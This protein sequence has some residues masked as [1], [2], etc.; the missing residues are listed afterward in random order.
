MTCN[1]LEITTS[2]PPAYRGRE[3][4][5][6][7]HQLLES[8]LE[9]LMLIVGAAARKQGRIEIC[10]VDCFSGPWGTSEL[11]STSIAVSLRT[12]AK[13]KQKLA[14]LGVKATMRALYIERD[15]QAYANLKTFLLHSTPPEVTS[16]C[17]H[18]DFV[19]LRSDILSWSGNTAFTFFFIDPKGWKSIGVE[20]LRPLV[21]RPRSEFLINFIYD[22]INRTASMVE[23]QA[24]IAEFL[25]VSVSAVQQ[26]ENLS[27]Q[28]RESKLL[29][30]YRTGLKAALPP[31]KSPFV[32]RTSYVR[33]LDTKRERAKY[34][35]IYLS[36]HPKGTIEFMTISHGVEAIQQRVRAERRKDK[37]EETTRVKDMFA[38]EM[39]MTLE[40]PDNA[41]DVD[42]YWLDVLR[43]EPTAIDEGVFAD[44]LEATDWTPQDLQGSL[45]RLVKAGKVKNL[46]ASQPRPKRPLHPEDSEQLILL[47]TR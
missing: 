30:H 44:I 17:R 2:I 43:Q 33:V 1:T 4:A 7:K 47:P 16:A 42:R 22:F 45:V 8:Y 6:I 38:D 11:E 3:Q 41:A 19:D 13:C 20:K 18:G 14:Q 28:D 5:W 40:G 32:G 9:K 36:S 15:D 25:G 10:Y 12:M 29:G 26:L 21:E 34:H 37:R 24:E 27:P 31:Q 46:N 23:W 39:P 35:L